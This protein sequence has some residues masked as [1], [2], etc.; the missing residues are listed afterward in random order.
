MQF[1]FF[2]ITPRS[3]QSTRLLIRNSAWIVPVWLGQQL[4]NT[5]QM[6]AWLGWAAINNQEEAEAEEVLE[7]SE[8]SE[9]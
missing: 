1:L 6:W 7:E 8:N 3:P 9:Y 2:L 4:F 5:A